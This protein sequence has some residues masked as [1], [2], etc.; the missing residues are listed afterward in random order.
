M[1]DIEI[2]DI[3]LSALYFLLHVP[4]LALVLVFMFDGWVGPV[5][6]I[7][8]LT[9]AWWLLKRT[10]Y[11]GPTEGVGYDIAYDRFA[12][13]EDIARDNWR[14]SVRQFTT[15]TDDTDDEN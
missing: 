4:L 5:L 10:T 3:S 11:A 7:L 9:V 13:P 1:G 12:Y 2:P 8:G 14:K 6:G 15:D